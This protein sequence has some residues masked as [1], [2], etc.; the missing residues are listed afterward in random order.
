MSRRGTY[1]TRVVAGDSR[2]KEGGGGVGGVQPRGVDDCSGR[3][4]TGCH[5]PDGLPLEL[6]E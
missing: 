2:M 3:K 5:D 1:R 4:G 6:H